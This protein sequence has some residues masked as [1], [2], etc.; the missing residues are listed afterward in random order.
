MIAC[1]RNDEILAIRVCVAAPRRNRFHA[2]M[3]KESAHVLLVLGCLAV[4]SRSPSWHSRLRGQQKQVKL[5]VT[6]VATGSENDSRAREISSSD[7]LEGR[8]H[9]TARRRY[10]R[11]IYRRRNSSLYGLK[12]AGDDGTFFQNV[13]MVNVHTLPET[14][15]S[16]V[17]KSGEAV[18]LKNLDDFIDQ[19]RNADRSRR[20][21]CT[22][23]FRRLRHHG[24]RIQLGRLQGRR[25]ERQSGSAVS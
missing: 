25:S 12:P 8:G 19:Q 15:F 7:L 1:S 4:F 5:E 14:S 6:A 16:L 17:P 13:P 2:Q 21:R 10:R 18:S 22:H 3:T 11:R 23:R 20:H 24:A 9:R